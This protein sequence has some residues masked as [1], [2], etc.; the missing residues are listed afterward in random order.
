MPLLEQNLGRIANF[1]L[2]LNFLYEN[3]K[4]IHVANG[5]VERA[6]FQFVL[7][8]KAPQ[9]IVV[10]LVA[11]AFAIFTTWVSVRKLSKMEPI[12]ALRG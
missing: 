3:S 1:T 10:T 8:S 9:V 2:P 5:F 6:K 12:Q 7:L 11:F 4:A